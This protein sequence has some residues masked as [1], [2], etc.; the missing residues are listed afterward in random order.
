MSDIE[1]YYK[2]TKKDLAKDK[3]LKY[4]AWLMPV[5]LAVLPALLFFILFLFSS[6]TPTAAMF[7]F[8][9]LL[10]LGVGFVIG[11]IVTGILLYYRSRWAA[12]IRE[13]I[14]VDGIRA[15][16]IDWFAHE[17]KTA[18]RKSLKEIEARNQLLGDAFRETLASR[19][20][21]TRILKT[22]KKEL[23]L[24]ERRQNKLK[25]LKS[26]KNADFLEELEK[27]RAN[28]EKIQTEAGEMLAEAETRLQMIEA[29]ARRGTSFADT[30][31]ALKKLSAQSQQLPLALE[32]VKMEEEIRRELEKEDAQK[33][34]S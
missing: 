22:T 5:L 13:R 14:A 15:D 3:A 34:E 31:I 28:L 6:A 11:L 8:L 7:F 10:S 19:L 18:E 20:T 30:E 33:L 16:E 12:E 25:Y 21:A 26:E 17:L 27:D 29:A 24:V 2:V 23:L 4:G 1:R 32:A 9:S